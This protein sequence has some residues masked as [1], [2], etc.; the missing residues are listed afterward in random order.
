MQHKKYQGKD[1]LVEKGP[2]TYNILHV[3]SEQ[4]LQH[5]V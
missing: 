1:K 3:L 5:P 2:K 4:N